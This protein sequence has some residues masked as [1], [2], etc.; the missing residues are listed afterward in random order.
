MNEKFQIPLYANGFIDKLVMGLGFLCKS[1]YR[2]YEDSKKSTIS[3][4]CAAVKKPSLFVAS[5]QPL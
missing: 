1:M 3:S 2:G 5:S 4:F